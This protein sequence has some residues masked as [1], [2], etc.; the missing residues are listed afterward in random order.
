MGT[1]KHILKSVKRFSGL[2]ARALKKPIPKSV[3]RF[4]DKMRGH[5]KTHPEKRETVFGQDAWALKKPIPKSVK[6][7]SG[8]DAR[9]LKN[10][11]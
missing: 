4:S 9:A 7:F 10:T 5:S 2:D 1:Q 11:S 6:R 3:K 8:L